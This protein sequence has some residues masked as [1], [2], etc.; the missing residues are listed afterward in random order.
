MPTAP[1]TTTRQARLP[2]SFAVDWRVLPWPKSDGT[3]PTPM[4]NGKNYVRVLLCSRFKILSFDILTLTCTCNSCSSL[5]K[6]RHTMPQSSRHTMLL[7]Q[8][9]SSVNMFSP[10]EAKPGGPQITIHPDRP[11]LLSP[12][13]NGLKYILKSSAF[14][15]PCNIVVAMEKFEKSSSSGDKKVFLCVLNSRDPSFPS[16]SPPTA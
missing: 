11:F 14:G 12:S 13:N 6:T 16:S 1:P 4:G 9:K 2:S 8:S 10:N 15:R 5:P 7:G 3:P